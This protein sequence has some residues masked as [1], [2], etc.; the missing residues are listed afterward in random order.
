MVFGAAKKIIDGVVAFGM[1]LPGGMVH[2][3]GSVFPF[4]LQPHLFPL[5]FGRRLMTH[6][7]VSFCGFVSVSKVPVVFSLQFPSSEGVFMEKPH[8]PQSDTALPS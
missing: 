2:N 5:E 4:F 6:S 3:S 1:S 8:T 7:Q